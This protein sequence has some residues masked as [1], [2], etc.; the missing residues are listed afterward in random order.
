MK[1]FFYYLSLSLLITTPTY[2]NAGVNSISNP[3][4]QKH[5]NTESYNKQLSKLYKEI[6]DLN[7]KKEVEKYIQKRLKFLNTASKE[8]EESINTPST[9]SIVDVEAIRKK[10]QSTI[11][12]Y[13]QIYEKSLQ[14]ASSTG[15]LD[16]DI[17]LDGTFYREKQA[18]TPE[19]FVPDFPYVT[20]QLS[21][22]KE[23]L[24]PAEEHIAYLLTTIKIEPIGLINV[25]ERFVF[26]SNNEGFPEGFFRILPKYTYSRQGSRRR[27]DFTLNSVTIN[28]QPH[29]YKT[30]EIG[31]NLYIEPQTPLNLP[32]GI[33]TYEFN[34]LIDRSIWSY[35]NYDEFY[36]DITGR[37]IKNVI[38]SANAVVI[39]PQDK[40]FL[41]Q[42]AT[43]STRYGLNA[44]RITINELA[45]N[46]LGFADTEALSLGEDIHLLITLDKDTLIPPTLTQKYLWFIQDYG[47]E[48][49]ALLVLLALYISYKISLTQMYKNQDKTRASIKKTPANWRMLNKNIFDNRSLGA[50]ILNLYYKNIVDFTTKD[51]KTILIKT[52]DATKS[53]SAQEKRL[54]NILFPNQETTLTSG[55]ESALKLKRAYQFLHKFT[56][57]ELVI[58]KLKLISL[59]LLSGLIMLILGAF[60]AAFLA[61]NPSHTFY[62]IIISTLL[63]LPYTFIYQISF[64]NRYINIIVKLTCLLSSIFIAGFVSIYTS[65]IYA[66]LVLLSISLIAYYLKL[67]TRR[68]ALMRHKVKETEDYKTYLQ[69]NP[70]L[71]IKA[72]DFISKTPYIYA[73]EI[74]N[75]YP[76]TEIF[77]QI[78]TLINTKG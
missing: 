71:A 33:Y 34:Y 45:P 32:T 39:L 15:A 5:V 74:E 68:N 48:L 66:I 52:T 18:S 37:T 22:D 24:A 43:A 41:A 75:K 60:G 29:K 2:T 61:T 23:I 26:V 59:Y 77:S 19:K 11:T 21:K 64:K 57:Q 51:N 76:T 3:I 63:I 40:T 47:A 8:D 54:L 25:T 1:K 53:L 13:E 70:E 31:N 56:L 58:F 9:T 73:F 27:L 65:K 12:A 20:I 28:G 42:N 49:F 67:F 78:S 55:K 6:P 36:W 7:N 44:E 35:Q 30:T 10:Q 50:E 69:K 62:V 16:E 46:S 17:K 4:K 14:R 72:S 38:G